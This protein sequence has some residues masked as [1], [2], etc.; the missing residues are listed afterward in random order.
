MV[1]KFEDMLKLPQNDELIPGNLMRAIDLQ[2]EIFVL[3]G[4]LGA[5]RVFTYGVETH[6]ANLQEFDYAHMEEDDD[7]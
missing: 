6:Y 7:T 2:N 4:L 5:S 1:M 3:V